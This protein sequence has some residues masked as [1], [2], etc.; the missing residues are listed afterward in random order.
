MLAAIDIGSNT[1]LGLAAR[2]NADGKLETVLEC[3]ATPRLGE[4]LNASGQLK[5]E[6]MARALDAVDQVMREL[7]ATTAEEEPLALFV[8]ATSAV[9]C[10]GNRDE[11][12][13]LFLGRFG[14]VPRVL[15]GDEEALCSFAGAVEAEADSPSRLFVTIDI[16]GGSTEI[17]LGDQD[18]CLFARSTEVG[19]VRLTETHGLERAS[20][21]A[22]VDAARQEAAEKLAGA[23]AEI[24]QR[25][26][27]QPFQVLETDGTGSAFAHWQ[28]GLQGYHRAATHGFV[29][30]T[31][32]LRS[33]AYEL[34]ALA[35]E[36]RFRVTHAELRRSSVFPAG[37]SIL[38]VILEALGAADC[39]VTCQGLRHG[40]ILKMLQEGA[41][42]VLR[43]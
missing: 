21:A 12:L 2:Q 18:R 7:R 19:C 32:H 1:V 28:L 22:A 8:G 31:A 38:T 5:P 37:L 14:F 16:G 20:A 6:A 29:A 23:C 43:P 17:C 34:G 41:T 24:R 11:F 3:G 35:A 9:R 30:T 33:A 40:M 15:S 27:T 10:A 25:L 36:E 13:R 42:F 39:Q 4:G 26:G